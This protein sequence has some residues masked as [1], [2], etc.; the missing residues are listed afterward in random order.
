MYADLEAAESTY[1]K[2]Q[3]FLCESALSVTRRILFL[4]LFTIKLC[5]EIESHFIDVLLLRL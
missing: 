5:F 3:V 4:K 2:S 1:K